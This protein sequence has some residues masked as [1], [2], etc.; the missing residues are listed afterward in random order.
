[1][2]RAKKI[3]ENVDAIIDF[4][5][6]QGWIGSEEEEKTAPARAAQMK[7]DAI[8]KHIGVSITDEN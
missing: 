6:Q 1:M 5:R 4:K 8:R 3:L 7:L 2:S